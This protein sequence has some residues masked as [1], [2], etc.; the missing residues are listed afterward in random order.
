MKATKRSWQR[1]FVLVPAVAA[2]L[3]L[4]TGCPLVTPPDG[5]GDGDGPPASAFV[6][7]E[8][9]GDCH[10]EYQTSIQ[11]GHPFK[12]NAVVDGEPPEYPVTEL[13]GPPTGL[14]W[15]D[16]AFVIGGFRYKYR[17]VDNDGFIV[18]GP[19]AQFNFPTGVQ[20]LQQ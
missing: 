20:R 10:T 14:T 18:L 8:R 15:D 1:A 5:D 3:A 19:S 12:L 17:V 2:I 16:V 6:G 7:S 9:C 11:T 4:V 13:T